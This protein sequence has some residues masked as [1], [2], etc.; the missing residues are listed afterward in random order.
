M[1]SIANKTFGSTE[2]NHIPN[3]DDGNKIK[4]SHEIGILNDKVQ[5][6]VMENSFLENEIHDMTSSLHTITVS[7]SCKSRTTET[8]NTLHEKS[9]CHGTDNLTDSDVIDHQLPPLK[10]D[11]HLPKIFFVTCLIESPLKMMENAFYFIL[12]ALFVLKVFK[13]L[14][15]LLRHVGK[16]A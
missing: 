1:L 14:S 2:I 13:F 6:L 7:L 9:D 16:T 4:S 5:S 15:R 10:S 8:E 3:S 11:S 12:K